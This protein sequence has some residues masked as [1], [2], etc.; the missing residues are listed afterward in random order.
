M[1]AD[2]WRNWSWPIL[3]MTIFFWCLIPLP[4]VVRIGA[5]L[6]MGYVVGKFA[7]PAPFRN[8]AAAIIIAGVLAVL[9]GE[10]TS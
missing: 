9:I 2:F 3:L 1:M 7:Y 10:L 6:V 8:V 4:V 5:G